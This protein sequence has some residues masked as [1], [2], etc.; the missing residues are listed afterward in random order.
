MQLRRI[1]EKAIC[2]LAPN[3]DISRAQRHF[4]TWKRGVE[5]EDEEQLME[6]AVIYGKA[7]LPREGEVPVSTILSTASDQALMR[8]L[9]KENI[10]FFDTL[11]GIF[12]LEND[13]A[14]IDE[15]INSY[16][17]LER[18]FRERCAEKGLTTCY[19]DFY[20][21]RRNLP[22]SLFLKKSAAHPIYPSQEIYHTDQEGELLRCINVW[23]TVHQA[24]D[25]A[26]VEGYMS[27]AEAA[28]RCQATPGEMLRWLQTQ[29]GLYCHKNGTVFVPA[30]LVEAA[31]RAR[32]DLVPVKALIEQVLDTE[33]HV[34]GRRNYTKEYLAEQLQLHVPSW[35][36]SDEEFPGAEG[37]YCSAANRDTALAAL[38]KYLNDLPMI[39]LS[40]VAKIVKHKVP[41]LKGLVEIG[42]IHAELKDGNYFIS[43][44]EYDRIS[45]FCDEHVQLD[46]A[47]EFLLQM[48]ESSFD[49]RRSDDRN[50][51]LDYL[52]KSAISSR[53]LHNVNN[54]HPLNGGRLAL[55][56]RKT[57]VPL[58]IEC[59]HIWLLSYKKTNVQKVEILIAQMEGNGWFDS[60]SALRLFLK[61]REG[62][63]DHPLYDMVETMFRCMA[64][65]GKELAVLSE[66]EIEEHFIV[67]FSKGTVAAAE[68]FAAFLCET[69]LSSKQYEFERP[70]YYVETGAYTRECF[71][72]IVAAIVDQ[73]FWTEHDLVKKSLQNSRYADLWLFVALHILAAWRTTD[74]IRLPPPRL[75]YDYATTLQ[76]ISDGSYSPEDARLVAELYMDRV[77]RLR[78]VPNKT[79]EHGGVPPL[80]FYCPESCKESFGTILSIAG[81]HYEKECAEGKNREFFRNIR[82][83][84]TMRMFF[85]EAFL[86]ACGNRSFSGRRANKSLMQAVEKGAQKTGVSP[87]VAF[88]MASDIRSHKYSY[89]GPLSRTTTMYLE[90][91]KF[92]GY[93]A[94][95]IIY[96]MQERGI[97]SFIV[98][99]LLC[100]AYGEQYRM[101]PIEEQTH[102][103]QGVGLAAWQVD[104]AVQCVL[105][106]QESAVRSIKTVMAEKGSRSPRGMLQAIA[107]GE[108][109]GKEM[110]VACI[111]R[112]AGIRCLCPERCGCLGCRYE[113]KSKELLLKYWL[114]Y[115]KQFAVLTD[116]AGKYGAFEKKRA[117]SLL[118]NVIN[119]G[120]MEIRSCLLA[121]V[122]EREFEIYTTIIKERVQQQHECINID[123]EM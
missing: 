39:P 50:N 48:S 95:Y 35:L 34:R 66:A 1:F 69:G 60:V 108:A 58:V 111:C 90:D 45:R 26:P 23:C 53:L 33:P 17:P 106:A 13:L 80:Y 43:K 46:Q 47:I 112:A 55:L 100:M 31:E 88:T 54:A 67:P 36:V 57:D 20:H 42:C 119:P 79:K 2:E 56:V 41:N 76:K 94:E 4:N 104:G 91:G 27:L 73:D 109:D 97:M 83:P 10:P 81:A 32:T 123:C 18:T 113:V 19:S 51:L 93:S 28:D 5:S 25:P 86:A 114:N 37:Y 92:S 98:N 16:R 107:L 49:I 70:G 22:P 115:D 3:V 96:Q 117:R 52:E 102:L 71:A 38:C 59:C 84:L 77:R 120:I 101:L 87:Y 8:W 75:K 105:S 116:D 74:L 122:S 65:I 40:S 6:G 103:L 7:H 99:N 85:G 12:V 44:T 78:M 30:V 21:F 72:W 9:K 61:K 63:V 15:L 11:A 121:S 118:K 14:K 110:D 29:K 82:D 68:R 89:Q 62:N 64:A 24:A